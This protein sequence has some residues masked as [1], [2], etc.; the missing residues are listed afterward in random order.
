MERSCL[1]EPIWGGTLARRYRVCGFVYSHVCRDF[2][3]VCLLIVQ[4]AKGPCFCGGWACVQGAR[5]TSG[6]TYVGCSADH[7]HKAR[8]AA[9]CYELCP[10]R[11]KPTN[12]TQYS[13]M[14][15]TWH[16]TTP[17]LFC[18]L[19]HFLRFSDLSTCSDFAGQKQAVLVWEAIEIHWIIVRHHGQ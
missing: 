7:W 11:A 9:L 16:H 8:D 3:P 13:N 4:A 10:Q 12:H 17:V 15:V 1:E 6:D 14:C 18:F 2:N 5:W 19:Q